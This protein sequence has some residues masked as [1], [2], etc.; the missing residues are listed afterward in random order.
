MLT[1]ILT[2]PVQAQKETVW[3]VLLEGV[4]NPERFIQ[5]LGSFEM[6]EESETT[7]LRQVKIRNTIFKEKLTIDSVHGEIRHELLDHPA[8]SGTITIKVVPT[9][10]QNPMA[11]V[12]LQFFLDLV[13][14]FPQ[15]LRT[16][17]ELEI[18]YVVGAQ[19]QRIKQA[20]EE[21]E[22]GL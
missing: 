11:P 5:G 8:Y 18:M 13:P 10:V 20:A 2:M 3:S 19:Q 1:K 22:K 16:E 6:L 4:G 14:R 15:V 17:E 21:L 9:S 7:A 12:E